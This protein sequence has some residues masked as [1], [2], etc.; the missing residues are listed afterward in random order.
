MSLQVSRD[1]V[2]CSAALRPLGRLLEPLPPGER[3]L[4]GPQLDVAMEDLYRPIL[5]EV[6]RNDLL[7]ERAESLIDDFI[8]VRAELDGVVACYNALVFQAQDVVKI[9]A[10]GDRLVAGSWAPR[11]DL[12]LRPVTGD[13]YLLKILVR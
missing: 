11:L 12:E 4:L 6:H 8:A 1:Y 13:E 10:R 9:E 7:T 3:D 5:V 2:P